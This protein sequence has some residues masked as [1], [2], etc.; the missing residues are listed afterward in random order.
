MAGKFFVRRSASLVACLCLVAIPALAG[1]ASGETNPPDPNQIAR[2][3]SEPIALNGLSQS[4]LLDLVN[5]AA[6]TLPQ[7]TL[8][9][10][11]IDTDAGSV[12]VYTT[13]PV[14][15][16]LLDITGNLSAGLLGLLGILHVVTVPQSMSD[17]EAQLGPI[18]DILM[19]IPDLDLRYVSPDPET[20]V[21]DVQLGNASD[22]QIAQAQQVLS[23]FSVS[24][25]STSDP[26]AVTTVGTNSAYDAS[27]FAA[28]DFI[29]SVD[30][31]NVGHFCSSG[32][33][34][35]IGGA[36]RTVTAGH[37]GTRAWRNETYD[38]SNLFG[39]N[40]SMGTSYG[41]TWHTATNLDQEILPADSI[42]AVWTGDGYYNDNTSG[43]TGA[44]NPSVGMKVCTNGAFEGT[45]CYGTVQ[46][47]PFNACTPLGKVNTCHVYEA[48]QPSHYIFLGEGDSGGSVIVPTFGTNRISTVKVL[49]LISAEADERR[50]CPAFQWRGNFCS[51]TL[52]F[53]GIGPILTQDHATLKTG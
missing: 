6:A 19:A 45:A 34:V 7:D 3:S 50:P 8:T 21:I 10:T 42:G 49:G 2:A 12:T 17:M 33:G 37:C 22:E 30:A 35:T 48:I 44:L 11:S 40:Q 9:G 18:G 47:A 53:T 27:P 43:V 16:A 25:T 5:S 36:G 1:A 29:L 39:S 4:T 41:N 20:G 28:G 24:I 46:K 14:G 52:F 51:D 31:N 38:G 32:V 15:Q 13:L 26:A 23:A